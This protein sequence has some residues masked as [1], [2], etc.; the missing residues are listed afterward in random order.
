MSGFDALVISALVEAAL[1]FLV[2]RTLGW[3]SRGDFH[4][5]AASAAAT[6]ITH[7]QLWAA[8]L[9]AYDRFPFWQSASILESAVVVIEGVLI[10]WMAKLRIDRAMLA[11]L[12]ANSGSLAIGLWLNGPS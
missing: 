11:S 4:V 2:T 6:A 8:A 12:V 5:A 3:N 10:A 1:A 9:W 7:P